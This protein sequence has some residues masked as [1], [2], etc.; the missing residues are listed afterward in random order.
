MTKPG[1]HTKTAVYKDFWF[2]II[3]CL[4]SSEMID[5]LGREDSIFHR[6]ATKPFLIDLNRT[7]FTVKKDLVPVM[8]GQQYWPVLE[9]MK[10]EKC[11]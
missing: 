3:G 6:I 10:K 7:A 9:I 8:Y 1:E 11:L 2:K 5:S 4:V